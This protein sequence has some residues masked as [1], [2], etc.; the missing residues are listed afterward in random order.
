MALLAA[1]L[2]ATAF[3]CAF[4][5]TNQAQPRE[6]SAPPQSPWEEASTDRTRAYVLR[7]KPGQD[8]R[9]ELERFAKAN[10]IQA[11]FIITCVGSLRKAALRLAD[12]SEATSFDG[13][14]E[15]VSLVGTLSP[16]GPHLH[17]AISD[18]TGKTVGGHLVAGCE[19]YTTAELVIGEATGLKM[20]RKPDAHTGYD[21]LQ[22]S[23][24][25][26]KRH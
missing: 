2:C 15:I 4:A 18:G 25:T 20:R 11:G 22:V 10:N 24:K 7:L 8:L 9:L 21:E 5:Q 26:R 1:C 13:K 23:R 3:Q 6:Q 16:D 14:Y 12:K 17:I 19:I